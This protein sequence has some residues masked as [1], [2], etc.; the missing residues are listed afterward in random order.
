MKCLLDT[1]YVVWI[2]TDA[3]RLDEFPWLSR[4][5]PWGVSPVSLLELQFLGEV[6]RIEIQI[7][8]FVAALMKDSRFLLDEVPLLALVQQTL[9][10]AWTRDPFA[11]LLA[12]HSAARRTLLCTLDRELRL[13]HRY[14]APELAGA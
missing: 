14:I 6:G 12:A 4:Y 13:H 1:H 2:V 5:E 11:R 10:L 7:D 3:A 9:P 8:E